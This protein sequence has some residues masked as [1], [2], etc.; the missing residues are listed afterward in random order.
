M[1]GPTK[2][3]EHVI[4]RPGFP[5]EGNISGMPPLDEVGSLPSGRVSPTV[6]AEAAED[7]MEVMI[8]SVPLLVAAGGG[9]GG[10]L[11]TDDA[12]AATLAIAEVASSADF[13]VV[14]PSADLAG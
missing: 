9:G 5:E 12:G 8:D 6:T 10:G 1:L 4:L 2:W 11:L 3:L 7:V 14:A 13:A